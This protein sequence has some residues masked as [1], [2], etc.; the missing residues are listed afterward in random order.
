MFSD[1]LDELHAFAKR[2][3]LRRSWFQDQGRLPHYDLHER[4]REA[5]VKAGVIE[6]TKREAVAFWNEHWPR[7]TQERSNDHEDQVH[8]RRH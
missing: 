1:N 6:L 4:R 3:G 7:T 2:I 8:F 5:A